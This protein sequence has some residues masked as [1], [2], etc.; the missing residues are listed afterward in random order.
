MI[1]AQHQKKK[2]KKCGGLNEKVV[3]ENGSMYIYG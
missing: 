3:G 2:K 1:P